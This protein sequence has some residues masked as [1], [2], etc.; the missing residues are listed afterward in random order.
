MYGSEYFF[1]NSKLEVVVSDDPI[2]QT[3]GRVW[4]N[5]K[6][7]V[8]KCSIFENNKLIIKTIPNNIV[9]FLLL[10]DLSSGEFSTI[11][12]ITQTIINDANVVPSSKAVYNALNKIRYK[13][14]TLDGSQLSYNISHGLNSTN[15]QIFVYDDNKTSVYPNININSTDTI[16]VT[17]T[18]FTSGTVNIV[19]FD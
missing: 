12:N 6:T 4:F 1:E 17:F 14:I 10:N 9:L 5:L 2:P 13:T 8:F 15:L 7:K 18:E 3:P 19:A 11:D 16:E